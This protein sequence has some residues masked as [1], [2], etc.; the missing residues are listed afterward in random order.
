M[1]LKDVRT[2]TLRTL[3][4]AAYVTNAV[5]SG[6]YFGNNS[7]YINF[8]VALITMVLAIGMA[9]VTLQQPESLMVYL[10]V[11]GKE[12]V[13]TFRTKT[14]ADAIQILFLFGMHT[15]GKVM[16]LITAVFW[17][18]ARGLAKKRPDIFRELFRSHPSD[19]EMGE[20]V[21]EDDYAEAPEGGRAEA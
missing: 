10:E 20:D 17:M 15:P 16:A 19:P 8:V 5:I 1:Q 11:S 6:I 7:M 9:L 12:I 14:V 3:F 13:F 18:A 21:G 4:A 2:H